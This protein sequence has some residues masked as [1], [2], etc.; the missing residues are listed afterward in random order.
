MSTEDG[1][2]TS[3]AHLFNPEPAAA[4]A[5]VVATEQPLPPDVGDS[6]THLPT[7]QQQPVP[8]APAPAQPEVPPQ[9]QSHMVP[10]SELIAER[11]ERQELARRAQQLEDS[12]RRLTQPQPQPVQ[13]PQIDPE[14]DPAGAFNALR[15]EFSQALLSQRLDFSEAKARDTHGNEAVDAAFDAAKQAGFTQAFVNRP[16]AYGEMVRWHKAQQLQQTIGN[17]PT[18]YT[19]QLEA[20]LRAKILAELKAG[21]PPPSNLPPSLSTATRATPQGTPEVIGSD[22]DFFRQTMNPRRG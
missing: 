14:V 9:P 10:L 6:Y 20:Q 21:T 22:K 11:R 16:D 19:Q 1:E 12:M 17:D 13:Q 3:I 15:G 4:P 5:P 8:P 18:A 2:A 7:S